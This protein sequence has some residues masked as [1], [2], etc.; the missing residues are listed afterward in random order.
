MFMMLT[1]QRS[2]LLF[3]GCS[4]EICTFSSVIV[5]DDQYIPVD[6]RKSVGQYGR[7]TFEWSQEDTTVL[8]AQIV[9]CTQGT[10]RRYATVFGMLRE[11]K[12]TQGL[13]DI[14]AWELK[15]C[16]LTFFDV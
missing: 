10:T 13:L 16:K 7:S 11:N 2:W 14:V 8:L 3:G 6:T 4:D 9:S 1:F 5:T 12:R 15:F